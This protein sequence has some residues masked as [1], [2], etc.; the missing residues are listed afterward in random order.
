M[1]IGAKS[2]TGFTLLVASTLTAVSLG[3]LRADYLAQL[4]PWT[5]FAVGAF[6][7]VAARAVFHFGRLGQSS[8]N[9]LRIGGADGA[10]VEREDPFGQ[11]PRRQPIWWRRTRAGL[12]QTAYVAIFLQVGLVTLDNRGVALL[13]ALPAAFGPSSYEY[14]LEEQAPEPEGPELAGC[15]LIRRAY[16]LGYASDLGPCAPK[17]EE[18]ADAVCDRR[19][20][21]EPYLHYAWR[22]LGARRADLL[23]DAREGVQAALTKID[24]QWEHLGDLVLAQRDPIARTP[25]ASHHLFTNL[26]PPREDVVGRV[27]DVLDAAACDRRAMNMPPLVA[28]SEQTNASSSIVEHVVGHLLFNPAYPTVVGS[29]R[30]FTIHWA[31]STDIC[32]RLVEGPAGVLENDRTLAGVRTVM[33]RYRRALVTWELAGESGAG[34][35]PPR[36]PPLKKIVSFQCFMVDRTSSSVATP[37]TSRTTTLHGH[38]LSVRLTRVAPFGAD[39]RDQIGTFK[40]LSRLL[41]PGFGYGSLQS[42]QSLVEAAAGLSVAKQFTNDRDLLSKLELLRETDIFLGHEWLD[43]RPDLLVVYPYHVHLNNFVEAFRRHYQHARTRL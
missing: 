36:P 29:C 26:P 23:P 25:R 20:L 6:A 1:R 28:V 32:D 34:P 42:E 11:G 18:V 30:E 31:A 16:E 12:L 4:D 21:D 9:F 22:L 37:V 40:H 8:E 27:V 10:R 15:S 19:Q 14:C 39:V 24:E 35:I 43:R 7:V 38:T 2:I 3:R 5:S 33:A 41:A 13:A 17:E